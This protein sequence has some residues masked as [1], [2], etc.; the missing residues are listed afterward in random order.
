MSATAD[1]SR[2]HMLRRWL[3]PG[4][5]IKRWLLVMFLGLTILATAGAML[6]RLLFLEVSPDS[7]MGRV[8]ELI[9]L[10]FLPDPL[11]PIL[12]LGTGVAVF[13]YGL[14][15]LLNV[16]LEPFPARREPLVEL[17]YQ[18]RSL[19]RGPRI[20]AIGGGTGQSTL[21]RGLKEVS[22]NITAV[23][24]VADDGGS[25]GRLRH[26]LGVPPVGD[27]RNCIAALADAE[28]TMGGLMKYRFP[29]SETDPGVA[30]HALGNLLIAA[31]TDIT[32][33]FEEA[34]RQTNQVLA[35]RGQVVPVAGKALNLTAELA[36]GSVL[37]GQSRIAHSRGIRRVW[38]SPAN[39]P[40][41]R[42]AVEAIAEAELVVLGPGSLYTSLLPSLLVPDIRAA[43]EQTHAL[44]VYVA[45]VATQLGETEGYTLSEH[46]A[47]L[48]A[49]DVGHLFD[50]VLANDDTSARVPPGY[51]AEPVRIDMPYA[52]TAK[53]RL[54]LAAVVDPDNAH[55]HDPA[56]LTAVL[57]RLLEERPASRPVA[58][59]RTA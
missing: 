26:E 48:A 53:P 19:A 18:K 40:A 4:M 45:N 28:P 31:M 49:H 22:S 1:E 9:S 24:T 33:D 5:G 54:E 25:S 20:V 30:G 8:F 7:A 13:V 12:V 59:V 21:L 52:D 34:V 23:V 39:V 10:N 56:R 29:A 42:E 41:S 2:L 51:P 58:P 36:D 38:L 6:L 50:M 46:V 15:R 47:A 37:E 43:L 57:M 35:V 16:L 55:R 44:R 17:V 11:R 32:G 3:K 14:W 27:I